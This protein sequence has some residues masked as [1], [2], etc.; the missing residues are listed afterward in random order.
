MHFSAAP[1]EPPRIRGF[2]TRASELVNELVEAADD[3]Q[4]PRTTHPA[5]GP[6]MMTGMN[7]TADTA[8]HWDSA[9]RH[10]DTTRSWFQQQPQT[11]L[12][13]IDTVGVKPTDSL[14]DVGGGTSRLVDAL[15]DRE[16][17][18]LTV[19]DISAEAL[20]TAQQRLGPRASRVR[21]LLADLHTWS[22][23]RTWAVWHDRAVLH[24]FTT[25]TDRQHYLHALDRATTPGSLAV[26]ATFALNGPQQCS[27]LPVARY[28][29]QQLSELL[30]NHW[31]LLADTHEE[32]TTP[33]GG[34]QPFTWAAFRRET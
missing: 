30:G 3:K 17:T 21:W 19:L 11:S 5:A 27:G 9:Y 29:A 7:G 4:R 10:G 32:H 8:E 12:H 33:S 31:R 16:H 28:D 15:L 18:D 26:L 6:R 25:Q 34:R 2:Y 23:D 13:M 22:P 20:H 14:I 24:F 1:L